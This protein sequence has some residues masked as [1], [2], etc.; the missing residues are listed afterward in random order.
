MNT[1]INI[2]MRKFFVYLMLLLSNVLISQSAV[3]ELDSLKLMLSKQDNGDYA[4]VNLLNT[5]SYKNYGI[6]PEEIYNYAEKANLLAKKIGFT[7]GEARS[8]YLMGVYYLSK[9]NFKDAFGAIEKSLQLYKKINESHGESTCYDLMGTI[10]YY[11]GNYKKAIV[12]YQKA[13]QLAEELGSKKKQ[14]D[15]INNIGNINLAQGKLDEAIEYYN[16]VIA[17]YEELNDKKSI[18][19]PLNNIA[20]I[21][22]RQGKNLE[23]LACFKKS[24][25]INRKQENKKSIADDL[26]NI[27]AVYSAIKDYDKAKESYREASKIYEELED[28]NGISLCIISMANIYRDLGDQKKSLSYLNKALENYK[29]VNGKKGTLTSYHNIGTVYFK[30]SDF[31]N[32][33]KNFQIA[34]NIAESLGEKRIIGMLNIALAKVYFHFKNYSKSFKYASKGE[35]IVNELSLLEEQREVNSILAKLYKSKGDYK[36]ALEHHILYKKLNDSLFNKENIKK[37]AEL[38]YEYKYKEQLQSANYKELQLTQEVERTALALAKSKQNLLIG[39]IIF[40]LVSVVLGGI[41]LYQKLKNIKS[42][43]ENILMEQKLLRSQM[44][45]HFIF[46]CLSVLQGVILNREIKNAVKYLSRFSK[47]LRITL[48]NSRDKMVPLKKELEAL[49]H[50][51]MVQSLGVEKPFDYTIHKAEE[52]QEEEVLVP[53]MLIQPFVENALEHAFEEEQTDRKI[54]VNLEYKDNQLVCV[55]L[56]NGIGIASKKQSNILLKKSLAT[57]ITKDRLKM[58]SKEFKVD[59]SI[60]IKDRREINE[61][62]TEVTLKLPYKK[63]AND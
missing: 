19:I 13:L 21:Y 39:I 55:I 20:V 4:K 45:P 8:K 32:A 61:Q 56:D 40:L 15:F 1:L 24:L 2:S 12:H 62:G 34:L 6:A 7:K 5:I 16:Q 23:G 17:I 18:L 27:G 48:E 38:E 63:I 11:Q 41:I 60:S 31:K 58:L 59:S 28:K 22:T 46:N 35:K 36:T 52:V 42:V 26:I 49:Q 43:N 47:L 29:K 54:N 37:I 53:P 44:T 25:E 50:Y 30:E 3:K 57:T 51:V 14:A 9:G 33:E 10:S